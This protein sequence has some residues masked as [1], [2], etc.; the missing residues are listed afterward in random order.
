MRDVQR[1]RVDRRA[2]GPFSGTSKSTKAPHAEPPVP[3]GAGSGQRRLSFSVPA[4]GGGVHPA[5]PR[6]PKQKRPRKRHVPLQEPSWSHVGSPSVQ[7]RYLR[8]VT[9]WVPTV[10]A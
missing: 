3:V 10:L 7:T 8:F 9:A 4:V 2:L 6:R 1:T 5:T